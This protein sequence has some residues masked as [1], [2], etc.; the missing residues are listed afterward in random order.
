MMI[1]RLR[2]RPTDWGADEW[3]DLLDGRLGVWVMAMH[4]ERVIW[5]CTP[6][7]NASAAD[8]G[9]WTHP[10]FRGQGHAAAVT[11]AWAALMCAS[12]RVLFYSTSR[13]NRSSRRVAAR[14]GLRRIGFLWQLHSMNTGA[15]WTD[16][17]VRAGA[18][19]IEGNAL[20]ASAPIGRRNGLRLGRRNRLS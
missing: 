12:G 17:R 10:D 14:L 5:I 8:A 19:A 2:G 7:A 3:Q 13:T 4:G 6:V 1:A 15:G 11:A 16:P 9:V 18:S 20:Y